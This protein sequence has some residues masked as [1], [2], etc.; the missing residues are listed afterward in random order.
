MD[1]DQSKDKSPPE[2]QAYSIDGFCEAHGP[3]SRSTYYNLPKEDR[4]RETRVLGRVIITVE[5]AA[6]WRKRITE[7]TEAEAATK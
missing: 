1:Q 2:R 6:E 3:F 4:P 7:K 5:S